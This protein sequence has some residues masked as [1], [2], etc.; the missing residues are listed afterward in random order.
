MDDIVI[1]IV[2]GTT[3]ESGFAEKVALFLFGAMQQPLA[4]ELDVQGEVNFGR[5]LLLPGSQY[6]IEASVAGVS[7]HAQAT[8]QQLD[9][10]PVT[11]YVFS[12]T[13]DLTGLRA[14]G[15]NLV[16]HRGETDLRLEYLFTVVNENRPQQTVV[17]Q[18]TSLA[19]A[20]PPGGMI[21]KVE[22]LRGPYPISSQYSPSDET[23]WIGLAV[24]LPP[25]SNRL[26]VTGS[27]PYSGRIEFPVGANIPVDEW[28]VLTFPADMEVRGQGLE[29]APTDLDADMQRHRGPALAADEIVL[30]AI[31]GGTGPQITAIEIDT[32]GALSSQTPATSGESDKGGLTRYWWVVVLVGILVI[33]VLRRSKP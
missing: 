29:S 18:P 2:N 32:T 9:G 24:A 10:E 6:L 27:V 26:R 12:P 31:G 20:L 30:L 16:I 15:M 7:Y 28:S 21:Q 17:P 4:E 22:S 8:G 25:G 1:K 5:L 3:H 14:T 33:I 23:G 13:T 11:V 19:L